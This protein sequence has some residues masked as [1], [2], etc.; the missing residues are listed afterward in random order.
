MTR[1]WRLLVALL[2]AA[3][4]LSGCSPSRAAVNTGPLGNGGNRQ[5]FCTWVA[6]VPITDGFTWLHN[7]GGS[8]VVVARIALYDPS[9]MVLV[10]ADTDAYGVSS[11]FRG[12][13]LLLN[14]GKF[15][16]TSPA[17][18]EH[19]AAVGTVINPGRTTVLIVGLERTA[20]VGSVVGVDVWY[21]SGG[22]AYEMQAPQGLTLI[23]ARKD[24]KECQPGRM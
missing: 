20:S 22:R 1:L 10:G 12:P 9:D 17:W 4:V 14:G 16:P 15:P 6:R 2:L 7:G 21:S 5:I 8:P 13:P 3:L 23:P 18:K 11:G 24:V 19:R